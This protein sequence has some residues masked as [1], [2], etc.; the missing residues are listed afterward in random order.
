MT[1][2]L[3]IVYRFARRRDLLAATRLMS[4]SFSHLRKQVKKPPV[5]RPIH[6]ASPLVVHLHKTDPDLSLCAWHGKKMVGFAQALVR[7]KQWYL[8]FLFVLPRYQDQKV[9]KQLLAMAWRDAPGMSHALATFGYNMQAIGIYSRFGMTI[10]E[11]LPLMVARVD[12]L[13]KPTSTGLSVATRL[14]SRDLDWIHALESR[15]RGYAHHEEWRYW[16]KQPNWK[17]WIFRDGSRR[18]GYCLGT[19]DGYFGPVGA[20]SNKYLVRILSEHLSAIALKEKQTARTFCPTNNLPACQLLLQSGF[21]VRELIVFMSDK[22]Y[23]DFQRYVP[24]DLAVF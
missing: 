17:G 11:T 10:R 22:R 14:T 12:Q 23:G 16:L 9:G 5:V 1:T 3:R 4:E 6:K 8:A 20:I 7:G 21:R 13:K 19:N 2:D 18:V 24:A 15:I